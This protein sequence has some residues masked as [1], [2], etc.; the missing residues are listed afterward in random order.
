VAA[1]RDRGWPGARRVWSSSPLARLAGG[2]R[3]TRQ[4][5]AGARAET[6]AARAETAAVRQEIAAARAEA[7]IAASASATA[8][9]ELS[10][11]VKTLQQ[12]LGQIQADLKTA[13]EI[14]YLALDEP[15]TTRRLLYAARQ[16]ADYET[17][18]TDPEPLVSIVIPTLN[19]HAALTAR[20]LPSVFAQT[21]R[22][23]EVIVIGDNA[24][25]ELVAAL[26]AVADPR[27]RFE[28]LTVRGQYPDDAERRW[29][30]A[31]TTPVNRGMELAKG[32]WIAAHNDDDV[33]RPDHVEKLLA[34]AQASH[35]EVAFGRF[36][37]HS[38][39]G[40]VE[41]LGRMPPG[42]GEFAFQAALVHGAVAKLFEY[43]L[44]AS[45]I[46]NPGDMHRLNRMIRAG[47]SFSMIDDVVLDYYPSRLW[48][49]HRIA[50]FENL[51]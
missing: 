42:W 41:V 43:E 26:S 3:A 8:I 19:N 44:H 11:Q 5:A 33:L 51:Q 29:C 31:G 34:R 17:A 16:S 37:H 24:D 45:M 38:P 7:S 2:L 1:S 25:Q 4:D 50:E 28:N 18:F 9:S 49:A 46:I 30:V 36:A 14:G 48:Q 47:V 23:I 27:L 15:V 21:Y 13:V 39:G 35:T 22:N 12:Q 40:E 6:A 32:Q 10:E 20:S